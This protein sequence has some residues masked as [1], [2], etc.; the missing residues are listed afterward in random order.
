MSEPRT[1]TYRDAGLHS[2]VLRGLNAAGRALQSVGIEKPALSPDGLLRAARVD[3]KLSDFGDDL[4]GSEGLREGL[5][6]LCEAVERG[7]A[8]TTFGRIVMKGLIVGALSTR[9]KL[10]DFAK[11]HPEVREEKIERPFV[12][13]GLPRTGTSLLS[14]LLG[15]DPAVRPLVQWEASHPVPPPTLAG[16]AED[17]RIAETAETFEKLQSLNPALRAMHPF[18]ATLATECVALFIFDMRALSVETQAFVP[19]YGRWLEKTDM[20]D[21]YALHRLGL[22]VL[23][24]SLPT[25]TWS[26]KTPNHLWCLDTLQEFYPDA[27]IIFTHRDLRKVVP[28]LASLVTSIQRGN[29]QHTD[30]VAV[31]TYWNDKVEVAISR[32]MDFDERQSGRSWCSHVRYADLMADPIETVRGIYAHFGEDLHPLH[33][34]RM[35]VWMRDR[36]QSAFGRHGYTFADFGLDPEA[37]DERYATYRERYDVPREG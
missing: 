23:Q 21:A 28:S 18:G 14:I 5:D 1:Y 12:I 10:L 2:R 32:A 30:P 17:P 15:L 33:E 29:A 3:A 20:R 35:V 11:R 9:L 8:L 16:H 13:V 24:S 4:F 36:G 31:G 6:V 26:L 34:K 22:Q 37:I 7:A 19:S 25:Q 27:R